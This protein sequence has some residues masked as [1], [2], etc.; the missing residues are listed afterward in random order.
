MGTQRRHFI[1]QKHAVTCDIPSTKP[2]NLK[3]NPDHVKL[4]HDIRST[5]AE[6]PETTVV[7][8]DWR[9]KERDLKANA[10]QAKQC[11]MV[12]LDQDKVVLKK[13][14]HQGHVP[15][16]G[17]HSGKSVQENKVDVL[18]ELRAVKGEPMEA[19]KEAEKNCHAK[20]LGNKFL[21]RADI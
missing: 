21:L 20:K 4:M 1:E 19:W 13:P 15:T 9:Q 7:V 11:L 17:M 14:K 2:A 5:S 16:L 18:S 12:S 3:H 10:I 6:N 8:E